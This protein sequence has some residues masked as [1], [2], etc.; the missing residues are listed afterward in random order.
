M[1]HIV[2]IGLKSCGKS[3]VGVALARTLDLK[4]IDTDT[5]LENLYLQQNNNKLTF[6]EIYKKVGKDEF[7]ELEQIAIKNICNNNDNL[8]IATGGGSMLDQ[9]NIETLKAN[10]K[11]IYLAASYDLL[12]KRWQQKPPSFVTSNNIKQQ[13]REYYDHRAPLYQKMAEYI[14]EIEGKEPLTI[15][16]EII[17]A[18]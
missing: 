3:S 13:L 2:L 14:I 10:G 11:I 5:E 7:R 18:L 4:F 17:S 1:P 12:L 8:V 15:V 16:T 6:Q 9:V